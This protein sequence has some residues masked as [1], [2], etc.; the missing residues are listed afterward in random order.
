MDEN[1]QLTDQSAEAIL[2]GLAGD[3][4]L[5]EAG[6]HLMN[7]S[8]GRAEPLCREALKRDPLNV[9][10]ICMLA[11]IGIRV[12][13]FGDAEKLLQRCLDLAPDFRRARGHYANVL[14]KRQKYE[15]AI[16]QLEIL[17]ADDPDNAGYLVLRGNIYAQ[18]GHHEDGLKHF[19]RVAALRPKSARVHMSLGHT[20]KTIGRQDDAVAAYRQAAL[21]EP[22]L[23]DAYWSLANLKTYRFD[24]AQIA[25][26]EA[27]A[28]SSDIKR[29]DFYHISFALAKA[30]EDRKD[31]DGA[32]QHY[33]RGNAVRRRL[34]RYDADAKHAEMDAQ[35]AFFTPQR[36]ASNAGDGSKAPDPIFV[37]GL[38]RAGS[39][40]IEQILASH[41][42]VDGTQEL[43]DIITLARRISGKRKETD[44]SRYPEVIADL[45]A[46]ELTALGEEYL[47]RTRIH[48]GEAPFFVD[49]MPNNF[50][51]IGLI[52]LILPN[53]K[54]IDARRNPMDCCFSCYKQLFAR[55]Q[56]FTYSL[57]EIGRYYSDYVDLMRHWDKV[58]PGKVLRVVNEDVI[59]APEREIRRLLDH[60]GLP[61][62]P[63]CLAFHE[64]DRA[65][66]TASSEQ[67]REPINAKGVDRWRAFERHLGPLR[68]ALGDLPETYRQ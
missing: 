63:A 10:A 32:F 9:N 58:L 28:A 21:C 7:G 56:N 31:Y 29:D 26:M 22:T 30:L 1:Q 65:V 59:E 64:T 41:S 42:Q 4:V 18:T 46:D 8:L 15:D 27:A 19:E 40:L 14:F 5:L 33:R 43:P 48:R 34:I 57:S 67:V 36:I 37:V 55:G 52:H 23:G 66:K 68:D 25:A 49:K 60:C 24:D 62:E 17:E 51:H 12:G 53:A 20:L 45:S 50:A 44:E 3:P 61:F 35:K 47:E 11:D 2:Q 16:T 6:E 13:A 39:T 54:I 38:P